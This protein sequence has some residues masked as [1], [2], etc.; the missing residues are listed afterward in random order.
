MTYARGRRAEPSAAE[1]KR[2]VKNHKMYVTVDD[3]HHRRVRFA[4]PH[5]YDWFELITTPGTLFIVGD[6]GAYTFQR[7][8]DMFEFFR[9]ATGGINPDYWSEKCVSHSFDALT[10]FCFDEFKERVVEDL[11]YGKAPRSLRQYVLTDLGESQDFIRTSD[12][13]LEWA[14]DLTLPDDNRHSVFTDVGEWYRSTRVYQRSF[15][16]C[17]RA[18]VW[19]IAKYDAAAARRE[20]SRKVKEGACA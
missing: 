10:V 18:I 5:G 13:A 16:W 1:F 11:R 4:P 12:R 7:T 17:L 3:L 6:H 19:G 15:I 9:S 20:K 14:Y 2:T 8:T